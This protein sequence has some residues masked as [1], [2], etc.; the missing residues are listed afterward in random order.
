VTDDKS[1]VEQA[2]DLFVYAPLGLALDARTLLPKF[3]ERGRQQVNM[4]KVFGQFAVQ[5]SQAEAGKRLHAAQ[6]QAQSLLS[7]LGLAPGKAGD[8]PEPVAAAPAAPPP[9]QSSAAADGLAISAYDSLAAS[10]VIPRLAAL[11]T[12]ELEAVRSYEAKHRGRKTILT[13][14]AQLQSS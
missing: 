9:P 7:E 12:G 6:E 13:K 11:S 1:P 5:Q 14:I 4:A 2:L 3:A 8:Q 10:Q